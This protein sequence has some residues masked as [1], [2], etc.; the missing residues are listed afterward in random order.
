MRVT[1]ISLAIL[2][3]TFLHADIHQLERGTLR[4][5]PEVDGVLLLRLILVVED[6]IGEP[7]ITFH[8]AHDLHFLENEIEIGVEFRIVEDKGAVFRSRCDGVGDGFI[9]LLFANL[10][11]LR[12]GAFAAQEE[13]RRGG[14]LRRDTERKREKHDS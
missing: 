3:G 1:M 7:A 5:E 10:A 8:A 11:G 14:H 13:K 2:L 4:L 9:H 12:G 6:G